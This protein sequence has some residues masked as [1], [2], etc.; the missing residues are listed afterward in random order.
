MKIY[1][2]IS[3]CG[4]VFLALVAFWSLAAYLYFHA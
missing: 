2:H 1:D 3:P 4:W